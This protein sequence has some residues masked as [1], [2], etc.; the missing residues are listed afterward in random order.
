MSAKK[1]KV[2]AQFKL[3]VIR[4]GSF[5]PFDLVSFLHHVKLYSNWHLPVSCCFE[6]EGQMEQG[7]A[8]RLANMHV[9]SIA[10]VA[11][12]RA[13]I[14]NKLSLDHRDNLYCQN[15]CR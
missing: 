5:V 2:Q 7:S 8:A 12:E 10:A 14:E 15:V 11:L 1:E 4:L 9:P 3:G 13:N 6:L